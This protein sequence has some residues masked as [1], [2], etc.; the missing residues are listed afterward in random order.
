MKKVDLQIL[1]WCEGKHFF[2]QCLNNNVLG[3]GVTREEALANLNE[4]LELYFENEVAIN[5]VD[6]KKPE[7]INSSLVYA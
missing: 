2:A 7:L 4:A 6:I 5:L 1:A 3:F